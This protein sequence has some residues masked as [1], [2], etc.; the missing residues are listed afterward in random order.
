MG[1]ETP[2]TVEDQGG[3]REAITSPDHFHNCASSAEPS[4]AEIRY[5][6]GGHVRPINARKRWNILARVHGAGPSP[7][8]ES[9]SAVL[10]R[11]MDPP[12]AQE[13][14]KRVEDGRKL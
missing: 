14:R 6:P 9:H 7:V 8:P 12:L 11:D 2:A 5:R 4:L 1:D 13:S 10:T 3:H